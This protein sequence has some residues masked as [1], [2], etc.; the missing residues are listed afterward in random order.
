VWR[1]EREGTAGEALS[2]ALALPAGCLSRRAE[3]DSRGSMRFDVSRG[4]G[5]VELKVVGRS[6]RPAG[7]ARSWGPC[8]AGEARC[9]RTSC[10]LIAAG[11]PLDT[12]ISGRGSA[13]GG[14]GRAGTRT[15]TSHPAVSTGRFLVSGEECWLARGGGTPPAW[16]HW[17]VAVILRPSR[18]AEGDSHP[19]VP[20]LGCRPS[21]AAIGR[22]RSNT[23]ASARART[24]GAP[25]LR[26]VRL[27]LFIWSGRRACVSL[28]IG[29]EPVQDGSLTRST[30]AAARTYWA[31]S[32]APLRDHP[33]HGAA[34]LSAAKA[35]PASLPR[36]LA[37]DHGSS[38]PDRID[39]KKKKIISLWPSPSPSPSRSAVPA[40]LWPTAAASA[41]G[42][43]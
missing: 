1:T 10:D 13:S 14:G 36:P 7:P 15:K 12:L 26:A 43:Y 23:A 37:R 4:V 41:A 20:I 28:Q 35:K 5:L 33:R 40:C 29:A 31:T 27:P 17:P 30:A 2:T 34:V 6:G 18:F 8:K 38:F 25:R 21:R 9:A 32:G 24:A 11:S 19:A 22:P 42:S 16:H 3:V 39:I